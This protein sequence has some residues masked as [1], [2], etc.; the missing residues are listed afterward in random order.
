M[1]QSPVESQILKFGSSAFMPLVFLFLTLPP[2]PNC[3][4]QVRCPAPLPVASNDKAQPPAT[5]R[6]L[7][8]KGMPRDNLFARGFDPLPL[9]PCPH[10]LA[11]KR[12][13]RCVS[14][15]LPPK[16]LESTET[17]SSRSSLVNLRENA[18]WEVACDWIETSQRSTSRRSAHV[19]IRLLGGARF[20]RQKS[21][22]CRY[23]R[24]EQSEQPGSRNDAGMAEPHPETAGSRHRMSTSAA[25]AREAFRAHPGHAEKVAASIIC[26]PDSRI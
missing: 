20:Q 2:F 5:G 26:Q 8:R 10:R 13:T 24:S 22:P 15:S 4:F 16:H 17:S 9:D 11:E 7:R 3:G 6:G 14:P 21:S 19:K 1:Q 25:F 18:R 23:S 12:T